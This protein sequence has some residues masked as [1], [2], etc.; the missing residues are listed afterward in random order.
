MQCYI[1]RTTSLTT[2]YRS[3]CCFDCHSQMMEDVMTDM[4]SS[5]S[6][7][8]HKGIPYKRQQVIHISFVNANIHVDNRW[9]SIHP[10][11]VETIVNPTDCKMGYIK[12][13]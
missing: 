4:T 5:P 8:P 11:I 6:S 1:A 3:L 12:E 2:A 7:S 10:F 9:P 13:H